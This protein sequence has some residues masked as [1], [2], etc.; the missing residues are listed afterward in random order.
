MM[1]AQNP[2]QTQR[3]GKKFQLRDSNGK[4]YFGWWVTILG[5]ILTTFGYACI[6]SATGVFLLPVTAD[7]G[8]EIA[9]FTTYIMIMAFGSILWLFVFTRFMNEK[10]MRPLLISS[11]VV[12]AAS[13]VGF[14]FSSELWHFYLLAVPMGMTLGVMTIAPST[15][16][17]NNWFGSK[18]KGFALGIALLG[19][20][21]GGMVMIYVLNMIVQ[22]G[23]WRAGF[24]TI[25]GCLLVVCI[26][27][28]LVLCVWSP[29]NKGLRRIGEDEEELK[30]TATDKPGITFKAAVRKPL[31]W[32]ILFAT[33]LTTFASAAILQHTQAYMVFNDYTADFGALVVSLCTGLLAVG[34]ILVGWYCDRFSFQ[35]AAVGTAVIFAMCFFAQAFIPQ[36]GWLVWVTIICYGIGC[37]AVNVISP[38]MIN[39][40]F[41]EKDLATFIGYVNIFIALGGAF[42]AVVVGIIHDSSGS[43]VPAWLML[44]GVLLLVALLRGIATT[45]KNLFHV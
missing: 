42:S 34:C 19:P 25:A 27:A 35:S 45:K 40:L 32:I 23:G 8:F 18:L 12:G 28:I 6:I 9:P 31:V 26:P 16:L 44:G 7:L 1:S 39:H 21:L 15:I 13:F 43:Y 20:S 41:G 5:F 33:A 29:E 10:Q 22:G 38:L 30:Q 17:I 14:A 37:P 3:Q 24:L 36:A 4:I 11:A 2:A